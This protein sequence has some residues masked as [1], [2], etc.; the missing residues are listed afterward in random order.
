MKLLLN[1]LPIIII[2]LLVS[3]SDQMAQWSHSI[4]GKFFAIVLIIFYTKIDILSGL[5][6]CA[7]VILY[8]QTDFVEGFAPKS[9][10]EGFSSIILPESEHDLENESDARPENEE[11]TSVDVSL[12]ILADAYP[13]TP[14]ESVIYDSKVA[15]FRQKHCSKGHLVHKGQCVSNEMAEHVFP[16]IEQKDFHKCNIC[17]YSCDFK[18]IDRKIQ[19][20]D[21]L[22][23]PLSGR[24]AK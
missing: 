19:V 13:D 12:E 22:M 24:E 21:D 17:D 4:L 18:F 7:L 23:K 10:V 20:Q 6:V 1:F 15:S 14:T 5:L 3:Y 16:E 8:Y 2:F 11:N 9:E